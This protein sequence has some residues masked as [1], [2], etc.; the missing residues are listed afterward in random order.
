MKKEEVNVIHA[1]AYFAF[2]DYGKMRIGTYFLQ[3]S[4]GKIAFGD[5]SMQLVA[6]LFSKKFNQSPGLEL[7]VLHPGVTNESNPSR[8]VTDP[9]GTLGDLAKYLSISSHYKLGIIVDEIPINLPL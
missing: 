1:G 6:L 2:R 9:N 7:L 5:K 3:T 8:P 4:D